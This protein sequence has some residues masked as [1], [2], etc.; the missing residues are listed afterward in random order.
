M[1]PLSWLSAAE[2][3]EYEHRL[4]TGYEMR[5]TVTILTNE[6]APVSI[7]SPWVVEGQVNA[8]IPDYDR[9]AERIEVTRDASLTLLDPDRELGFDSDSPSDG[10]MY[11]DRMIGIK[12]GVRCSFGW[13]DVPIFTGPV[14]SFKRDSELVSITAQ[15]KE[16]FGLSEANATRTYKKGTAK[17]QVFRHLLESSGED[18]SLIDVPPEKTGLV[19]SFSIAHESHRWFQA[20][21]VARSLGR[22]AYYDGAG[23]CRTPKLSTSPVWTFRHGDNGMLLSAPTIG[24]S[25]DSLKNAARV[26]GGS[27]KGSK[28][29][30]VGTAQAPASSLLAAAKIGRRGVGRYMLELEEDSA[31]NTKAKVNARAKELLKDSLTQEVTTEFLALPVPHLEPI[32]LVV[33]NSPHF[34][35]ESR[36]NR[37]SIPLTHDGQMTVGFHDRVSRPLIPIARRGA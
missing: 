3:A 5:V 31:L 21:R 28:K 33:V 25:I 14:T 30:V 34:A 13:V 29:K 9:K 11:L 7:V 16:L 24:A 12:Y 36:V 4:A 8:R 22:E 10:A 2:K 27:P 18:P 17:N 32:D 19:K 35:A 20:Y 15:G 23:H 37:M 26:V 6:D 1:F